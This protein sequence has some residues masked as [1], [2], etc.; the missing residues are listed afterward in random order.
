MINYRKGDNESCEEED[1]NDNYSKEINDK[2]EDYYNCSFYYD[3][4]IELNKI[5]SGLGQ[6][7]P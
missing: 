4:K 7:Y 6:E 5:M 3:N 1:S 2:D